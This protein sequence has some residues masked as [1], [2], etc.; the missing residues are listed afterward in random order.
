MTTIQLK[1]VTLLNK[2]A[3]DLEKGQTG[4]VLK[5]ENFECS[6]CYGEYTFEE[7]QVKMLSECGHTFC[8]ECFEEYFRSLIEDQNKDH[9]LR[10]PQA[11]CE[12]KPTPE[13]VEQIISEDCFKKFSKFQLNRKVAIDKNLI[14]CSK[15]ECEN[16]L[17]VKEAVKNM[18]TCSRCQ[19]KTCV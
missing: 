1:D 9:K 6:I 3:V 17:S 8:G 19:Q 5:L 12:T 15:V 14:F 2:E 10:C 7:T 16:V 18:A 4:S 13:E 11:G